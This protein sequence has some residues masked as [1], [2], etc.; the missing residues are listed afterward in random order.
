MQSVGGNVRLKHRF[1]DLRPSRVQAKK[2]RFRSK[3]NVLFFN[4][5][6]LDD[7]VFF[8]IE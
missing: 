4:R 6:Y 3:G 7:N 8:S 5:R 2:M 1:I